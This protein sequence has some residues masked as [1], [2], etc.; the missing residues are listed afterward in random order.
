MIKECVDTDSTLISTRLLAHWLLIG[1]WNM[2]L[3]L[4]NCSCCRPRKTCLTRPL[5]AATRLC[6]LDPQLNQTISNIKPFIQFVF[7][8]IYILICLLHSTDLALLTLRLLEKVNKKENGYT[9][10]QKKWTFGVHDISYC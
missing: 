8:L 6:K 9:D 1:I 3:H 10:M 5:R 4:W 7:L 2:L